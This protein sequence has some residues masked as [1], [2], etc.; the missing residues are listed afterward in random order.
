MIRR[1][2]SFCIPRV[3]VCEGWNEKKKRKRNWTNLSF[4]S[5]PMQTFLFGQQVLVIH[6]FFF[7]C[8]WRSS[9]RKAEQSVFYF[10]G[11]RSLPQVVFGWKEAL[12]SL[13][14]KEDNKTLILDWLT[15][16]LKPLTH[17][18]SLS[19]S[20]SLYQQKETRIKKVWR[21]IQIFTFRAV[22][23]WLDSLEKYS[24]SA[25]YNWCW[26]KQWWR[27]VSIRCF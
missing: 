14:H 5:A 20:L 13:C 10:E 2:H 22:P 23:I 6:S 16:L 19:L 12:V 8:R 21:D 24:V 7:L 27:K 25:S 4:R 11:S 18:L 3:N 17:S 26:S 1:R 15:A 9:W